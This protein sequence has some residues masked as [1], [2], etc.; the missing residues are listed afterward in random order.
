MGTPIR[1]NNEKEKK[2]RKRKKNRKKKTESKKKKKKK[3]TTEDG[4]IHG[5]RMVEG[6]DSST[7]TASTQG[8]RA[9]T[10]H[11]AYHS[12]TTDVDL[13]M[14]Y[15]C[16]AEA[17]AAGKQVQAEFDAEQE[18]RSTTTTAAAATTTTT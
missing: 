3:K 6:T 18:A 9:G 13:S 7:A 12:R 5:G 10:D 4:V 8:V 15:Y 11:N 2:K 17:T 16:S 1:A 14:E